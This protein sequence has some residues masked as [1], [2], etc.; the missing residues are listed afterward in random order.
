ML[1]FILVYTVGKIGRGRARARQ[2][3]LDNVEAKVMGAYS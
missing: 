2:V 1:E 3:H